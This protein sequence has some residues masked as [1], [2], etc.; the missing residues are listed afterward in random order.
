MSGQRDLS[1]DLTRGLLILL[2]ASTHTLTLY[3]ID[4]AELCFGDGCLP[5]GWATT[6]F[7]ML[8]GFTAGV[9]FFNDR[10]GAN[11][12]RTLRRRG[13][14][15]LAIM[16]VSNVVFQTLKY[17]AD[18]SLAPL[19]SFSWWL[20]LLTFETPY[21]IS[22]ILIPT[23]LLLLLAPWLLRGART[24]GP[25]LAT[26]LVI[27]G[28]LGA[29]WMR[30]IEELAAWR[31]FDLALFTG[32]G[33]FPVLWLLLLGCVGLMFGIAYLSA[34]S[35]LVSAGRWVVVAVLY[36]VL[37]ELDD[38]EPG[39]LAALYGFVLP[40]L[41]FLIVLGAGLTLGHLVKPFSER[42][43]GWLILIGRYGLFSFLLHRV[44]L[45]AGKIVLGDAAE[46]LDD[47]WRYLTVLV[48][49][50]ATL[51][52]FCAARSRMPPVDRALHRIGL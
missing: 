3:E 32:V 49:L 35:G 46:R 26:A 28:A 9:L 44:F 11:R 20:G 43:L 48:V 22:A 42:W 7:V 37:S 51:T 4:V 5:R 18:G 24:L 52:A 36:R 6:S 2:M 31:M 13:W 19:A 27:A 45:Q 41:R 29:S 33:G 21:S 17:A 8:S 14:Q 23:G 16:L 38:I 39:A 10:E 30:Q 12:T 40:V 1:I 50:A 47:E 15:I 34:G 25:G